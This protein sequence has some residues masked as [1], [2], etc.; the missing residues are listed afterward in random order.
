MVIHLVFGNISKGLGNIVLD[1]LL[2]RRLTDS[3]AVH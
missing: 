1:G 3:V 2:H